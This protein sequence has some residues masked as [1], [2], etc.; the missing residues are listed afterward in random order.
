MLGGTGVLSCP[1]S[2][3]ILAENPLKAPSAEPVGPGHPAVIPPRRLVRQAGQI[4]G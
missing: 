2:Q 3:P 1:S 4:K